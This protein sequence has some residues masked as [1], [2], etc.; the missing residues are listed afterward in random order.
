M[1][2]PNDLSNPSTSAMKP[3]C[4]PATLKLSKLSGEE[5]GPAIW[6][7]DKTVRELKHQL[8]EEYALPA[9]E[10]LDDHVGQLPDSAT[11][12]DLGWAGLVMDLKILVCPPTLQRSATTSATAVRWNAGKTEVQESV[13]G[14]QAWLMKKGLGHH[15]EAVDR[16]CVEMGAVDITEVEECM[17]D[18]V[19]ALADALTDD[20]KKA[21]LEGLA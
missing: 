9:H 10:L 20:E 8:R 19:D 16:W 2:Q 17:Q 15:F 14:L 21:F 1:H 13:E 4:A 7:S 3:A 5:I 18:L 6:T 11:V 12:E